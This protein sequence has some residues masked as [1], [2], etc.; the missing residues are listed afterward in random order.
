MFSSQEQQ[1][2][3]LSADKANIAITSSVKVTYDWHFA[4]NFANVEFYW[5]Y[6]VNKA[7]VEVKAVNKT[8]ETVTI[9]V[10]V[11]GGGEEKDM[12][13]YSVKP[14]KHYTNVLCSSFKDYACEHV[15]GVSIELLSAK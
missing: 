9:K 8:S 11:S 15:K 1:Q 5:K 6:G 13:F 7:S 3:S 10:R 14:G 2:T 12:T 4:A